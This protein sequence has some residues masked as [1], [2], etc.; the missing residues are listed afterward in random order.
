MR[1]MA[2]A[3]SEAEKHASRSEPLAALLAEATAALEQARAAVAERARVAAEEAAAAAAVKAAA[4]AERQQLE[5][6]MAAATLRLQQ[7]QTRL[8]VSPMAPAPH[9]EEVLC[10]DARMDHIIIPCG[11]QCVCKGCAEPAVHPC[12]GVPCH[13]PSVVLSHPRATT[14]AFAWT[15]SLSPGKHHQRSSRHAMV[16]LSDTSPHPEG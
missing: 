12:T 5:E 8:G 2:E 9:P 14:A 6:E 4:A 16:P 10:L 13:P 3:I 15:S 1:T 7:M 11:H